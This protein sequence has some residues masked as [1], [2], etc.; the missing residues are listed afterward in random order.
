MV[1]S[2]ILPQVDNERTSVLM[3]PVVRSYVY[4][5]WKT[6][7]LWRYLSYYGVFFLFFSLLA[8]FSVIIPHPQT[9]TCRNLSKCQ[10]VSALC[11][12]YHTRPSY[13]ITF[14]TNEIVYYMD[15]VTGI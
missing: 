10:H 6:H 8:L 4:E 7:G 12:T 14:M 9:N 1:Y 13:I 11:G 15:A 2:A 3:H 5:K